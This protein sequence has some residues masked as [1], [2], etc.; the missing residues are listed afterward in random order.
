MY[1]HIISIQSRM[2]ETWAHKQATSS[3]Y[4]AEC[5]THTHKVQKFT[6]CASVKTKLRAIDFNK[7]L[8]GIRLA[9]RIA[10]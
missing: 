2:M 6:G 5:R 10:I 3:R 8:N 9:G 1:T 7:Y 4:S